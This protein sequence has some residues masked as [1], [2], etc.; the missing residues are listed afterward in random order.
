M[1]LRTYYLHRPKFN[2]YN[3]TNF[4]KSDVEKADKKRTNTI[5]INR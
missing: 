3:K 2:R 4:N 5:K 1:C